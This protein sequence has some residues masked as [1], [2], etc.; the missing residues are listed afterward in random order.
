AARTAHHHSSLNNLNLMRSLLQVM[1]R[2]A[3]HSRDAASAASLANKHVVLVGAGSLGS[4][5]AM[6]LA[7]AGVGRLTLIDPDILN[8]ENLGRH[9]LGI[10][11]LGRYKVDAMR[12]RLASGRR[13]HSPR[14]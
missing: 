12:D 7:R 4:Q 2:D 11:D 14:Q 10:D 8:A 9:V 1:S 13:S 3:V 6:Q 5:V